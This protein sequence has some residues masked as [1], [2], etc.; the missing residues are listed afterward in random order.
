M[1]VYTLNGFCSALA[2]I[3][4]SID[5]ASGHGL[6]A[7]GLELTVI[8]AVVIGGTLLTGGYGYV[9]GTLFGVLVIGVVQTLIQFNGQLSSWWTPI[10]V[11][12]LTLD[13]H[14]RAEPAGVPERS[15]ID[16][17]ASVGRG[18]ESTAGV[19][20]GDR[21]RGDM[22]RHRGSRWIVAIAL[23][24]SGCEYV[25]LP[26]EESAPVSDTS[27]GW[28]AV[29]TAVAPAAS[30][31]LRIDLAIRNETGDW[32]AMDAIAGRPA[33]LTGGDGSR[34]DC[35]T[36]E[37]ELGWPSIGA[38]LPDAGLHGRTQ[39]RSDD[40]TD[41]GRVRRRDGRSGRQA[42]RRLRVRDRRVR[43]LRRRRRPGPTASWRS[44][45]TSWRRTSPSRSLNRS[46]A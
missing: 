11:A 4:L 41:P 31:D 3:A 42:R 9:I 45:S 24:L 28:T 30:G 44:T 10:V 14:R 12:A 38:R 15:A 5:V 21:Q 2:G 1:L 27:K 20:S 34:T 25:V 13:L 39:S 29:A 35:A 17:P 32:S 16:R 18:P 6:Y 19:G 37:V 8:G 36:V 40:G 46:R 22:T 23:V 7:M 43:L 33:V 26:P